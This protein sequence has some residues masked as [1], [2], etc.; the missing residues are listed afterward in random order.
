MTAGRPDLGTHLTQLMQSMAAFGHNQNKDQR[1]VHEKVDE[2][3]IK[4]QD[5]KEVAN[6]QRQVRHSTPKYLGL[7]SGD[8]RLI[9]PKAGINRIEA[10]VSADLEEEVRQV[11]IAAPT[12]EPSEEELLQKEQDLAKQVLKLWQAMG[13][14]KTKQEVCAFIAKNE[15]GFDDVRMLM[16]DFRLLQSIPEPHRWCEHV[17][18]SCT[19]HRFQLDGWC[20][21]SLAEGLRL[22]LVTFPVQHQDLQLSRRNAPGRPKK[23]RPCLEVQAG[24]APQSFGV[25]ELN[26]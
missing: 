9:V 5:W 16:Q 3:V 20:K 19:C 10:L 14:S 15:L 17:V 8:A 7:T 21:H 22:K 24:E 6:Y 12:P 18:L 11:G 2:L 26:A 1:G 25:P 23:T 13:K 4:D